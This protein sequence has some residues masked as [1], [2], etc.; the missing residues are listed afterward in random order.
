MVRNGSSLDPDALERL[1]SL[2][3]P[4]RR[5]LYEYVRDCDEAT[6][7]DDAANATGISRTLAAYHLDKLVDAGLLTAAYARPPGRSGPGAGR[8]AKIYSRATQGL[9]VSVPPRDYELLAQLLVSSVDR[10][11]TGTVRE[12]VNL[13][14]YDAGQRVGTEA[15]GD[16][17]SALN[18]CGYQPKA[19]EDG[20]VDL[21]NCPF[22]ALSDEHRDVVCGLNHNLIR[23][24]L[25][26]SGQPDAEAELAFRPGRCCVII[27]KAQL[28]SSGS[29]R[30]A[31]HVAAE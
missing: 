5:R 27:H 26:A 14:A 15:G 31:R 29:R 16:L 19:S 12:I 25:D 20:R 4:V 6:G 10:D 22:H 18:G 24:V 13:A 9:T 28:D 7:R 17:L 23:G 11:S 1:S 21:C 2:G 8:P 3:D 30:P